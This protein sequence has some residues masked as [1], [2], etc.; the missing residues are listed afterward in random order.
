M[1]SFNQIREDCPMHDNGDCIGQPHIIH[2]P[3]NNINNNV[4]VR[5]CMSFNECSP[6]QCPIIY[7][8]DAMDLGVAIGIELDPDLQ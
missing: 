7:M 4:D 2:F 5:D 3:L 6:D 1:K 8:V